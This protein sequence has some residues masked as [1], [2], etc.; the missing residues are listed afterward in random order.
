MVAR[1]DTVGPGRF[2][3]HETNIVSFQYTEDST[4]STPGDE[5]GAVG[6]LS[7]TVLDTD[8]RGI[9][10]YGDEFRFRDANYGS[11]TGTV[12]GVDANDNVLSVSALSRLNR[13]NVEATFGPEV[14][15]VRGVFRK[16]F[17]TAGILGD[18]IYSPDVPSAMVNLPGF[19]GNLWT[20]M[21]QVCSVFQVEV[22]LL[23]NVIF[24]R[25]IRSREIFLE[26]IE[27]VGYRVAESDRS[28]K[29]DV[30]YYN[31]EFL[32]DALAYPKGGWTPDVQVY[33]VGA[34]ET[35]VFDLPIDAYLTSVKQPTVQDVVAKDYSGPDSVYS[36][37]G[38]DGLPIP[39]AFWSDFGGTMRFDLKENGTVIEV[40]VTAPDVE[41][42]AP[43]T[44]GVSDGA[45]QY[46]T[47]RI[48]GTGMFFDRQVHTVMTGLESSLALRPEGEEVDIAVVDTFIDAVKTGILAKRRQALPNQS[49]EATGR[50]LFRRTVQDFPYF[51]LD[52][53]NEGVL[54][55]NV[56]AFAEQPGVTRFLTFDE[57]N[58]LVPTDYLFS[59]FNDSYFGVTF[60][61]FAESVSDILNQ[62]IGVVAGARVRFEDAYY[63]VRSATYT[64]ENVRIGA[65]FD[66]IFADVTAQF[67]VLTTFDDFNEITV[68]LTF[69]DYALVPLRDRPILLDEFFVLD[70]GLL[71]VNILG[72]KAA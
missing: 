42:F 45:T 1:F 46:S 30:A 27:R 51:F 71:D 72:V 69:D 49:I 32:T 39:A 47:L 24:V 9:L 18:I 63:R 59:D 3:G 10:L 25:P 55:Q 37:S 23:S 28:E 70:T 41:Q 8:N 58:Q 13:L 14:T 68:G 44:I 15:N 61:D 26:S 7:V 62:T 50:Q 19:T 57:Y 65:D 38:N 33:S 31:Y 12:S 36:V 34:G 6:E 21:K 66:T 4:P 43:Y 52:D 67:G 2:K 29:F 20:F 48:V 40:T 54:D 56:L 16:I 22:S 64:P 35:V 5:S 11:L 17:D 53:P 60:D